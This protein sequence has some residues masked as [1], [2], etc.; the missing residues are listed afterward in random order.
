MIYSR[1]E[2]QERRNTLSETFQW[3][4]VGN[5]THPVTT[6]QRPEAS[7]ASS[8]AMAARSVDSECR[9][10]AMQP[11]NSGKCKGPSLYKWRGRRCTPERLGVSTPAGVGEQGRCTLGF[12]GDVGD[13]ATSITE[14]RKG[15]T[16][17]PSP[18][19][20]GGALRRLREENTKHRE[21]EVVPPGEGNQACGMGTGSLSLFIVLMESRET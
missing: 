5:Q 9:S 16:R 7:L 11:R 18:R 12:P 4:P 20:A 1:H 6:S 15:Q 10:R 21:P 19:P 14:S 17:L 2:T 13:P 8:S 3:N